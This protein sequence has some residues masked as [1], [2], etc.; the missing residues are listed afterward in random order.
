MFCV[1]SYSLIKGVFVYFDRKNVL[2]ALN[3]IYQKEQEKNIKLKTQEKFAENPFYIEKIAREQLQYTKKGE[4]VVVI[5]YNDF[6]AEI[7]D[8]NEQDVGK[9]VWRMWLSLVFSN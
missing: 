3:L 8:T 6:L 9:S 1:L 2:E 5:N 7:K 4:K